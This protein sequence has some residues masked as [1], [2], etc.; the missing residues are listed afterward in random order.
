[1]HTA[2]DQVLALLPEYPAYQKQFLRQVSGQHAT[3]ALEAKLSHDMAYYR[4]FDAIAALAE[5]APDL[6]TLIADLKAIPRDSGH[7]AVDEFLR[8]LKVQYK[9]AL[10]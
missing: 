6:K 10:P 9:T 3:T 1:V 5:L 2:K 4:Y 8:R 7:S